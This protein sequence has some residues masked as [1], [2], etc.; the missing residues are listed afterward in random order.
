MIHHKVNLDNCGSD[1]C[2]L[3]VS[4]GHFLSLDQVLILFLLTK[5]FITFYKV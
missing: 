5:K 2:V 4:M 1:V 3:T